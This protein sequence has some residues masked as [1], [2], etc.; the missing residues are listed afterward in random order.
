MSVDVKI[1]TVSNNESTIIVQIDKQVILWNAMATTKKINEDNAAD[2]AFDGP[3][4][5][6]DN[7]VVETEFKVSDTVRTIDYTPMFYL[8]CHRLLKLDMPT[9]TSEVEKEAVIQNLQ[10]KLKDAYPDDYN[11]LLSVCLLTN[12]IAQAMLDEQVD[13]KT[14]AKLIQ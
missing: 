10:K 11:K 2:M 12:S 13:E 14:I 4:L 7:K 1:E 9:P 5:A 3:T 6:F 8:L